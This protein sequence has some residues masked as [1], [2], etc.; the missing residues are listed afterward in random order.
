MY[1]RNGCT[2]RVV[3][4]H[5]LHPDTGAE[6]GVIRAKVGFSL[7]FSVN[8]ALSI[9]AAMAATE[10]HQRVEWQYFDGMLVSPVLPC[11]CSFIHKMIEF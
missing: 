3:A 4:L 5:V 8:A 1:G 2:A 6:M 10:V 9:V 7:R 11:Y